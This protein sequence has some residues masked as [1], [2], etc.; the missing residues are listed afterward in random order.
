MHDHDIL[1]P[2]A[3][4]QDHD[5]LCLDDCNYLPHRDGQLREFSDKC[6]VHDAEILL[7]TAGHQED[8]AHRQDYCNYVP[9][10]HV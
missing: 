2:A 6:Q 5:A 7:P 8:D 3:G 9:H 10:R 4:H 1:L